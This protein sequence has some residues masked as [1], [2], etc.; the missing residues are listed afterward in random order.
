MEKGKSHRSATAH[1]NGHTR[2]ATVTVDLRNITAHITAKMDTTIVQKTIPYMQES[3]R[4]IGHIMVPLNKGRTTYTT[5]QINGR[6]TPI[7]IMNN[8]TMIAEPL[9]LGTHHIKGT[10][11]IH[12]CVILRIMYI[13]TGNTRIDLHTQRTTH[14]R[15]KYALI[16]TRMTREITMSR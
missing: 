2:T 16:T 3:K 1:G 15:L 10:P 5:D 4:Q 8:G 14:Q 11:R 12:T 6:E 7:M 9:Q 13:E